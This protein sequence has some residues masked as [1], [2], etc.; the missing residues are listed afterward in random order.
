MSSLLNLGPS[1]QNS[2]SFFL[3]YVC[4]WIGGQAIVNDLL[5]PPFFSSAGFTDIVTTD[6]I[7][8]G[9]V[10]QAANF[11]FA[12]IYYSGH[13]V[14]FYQPVVALSLFNRTIHGMDIAT[15]TLQAR[16]GGGYVSVG[17]STSE[18]RE[19]NVTVVYEVLDG[20]EWVYDVTLG[21]PVMAGNRTKV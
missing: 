2:S 10:R 5:Q 16:M 18:F 14:P 20:A 7:T 3:D 12:R 15:G 19:G 21:K 4:N 13:E 17:T 6:N 1:T 11:A 9:Q 8:H